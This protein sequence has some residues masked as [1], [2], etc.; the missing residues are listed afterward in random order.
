M[1]KRGPLCRDK[2]RYKFELKLQTLFDAK[3]PSS[4]GVFGVSSCL[5]ELS[6]LIFMY[7]CTLWCQFDSLESLSFR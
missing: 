5:L 4:S 1:H 3:H 2:I 6:P 7:I